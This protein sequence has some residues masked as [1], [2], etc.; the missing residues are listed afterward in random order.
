MARVVQLFTAQAAD[1]TGPTFKRRG[2]SHGGGQFAGAGFVVAGTDGGGT[3]TLETSADEVVW[4]GFS[5]TTLVDIYISFTP[6]I[7]NFVRA[8]LSGATPTFSLD[9]WMME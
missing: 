6:L 7:T 2:A 8:T 3:L 1:G 5:V 9:V 4:V